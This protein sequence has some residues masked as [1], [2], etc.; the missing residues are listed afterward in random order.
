MSSGCSL[1]SRLSCTLRKARVSSYSRESD[2]SVVSGGGENGRRRSLASWVP[3]G[4]M[5]R[6]LCLIRPGA[7]SAAPL[8]ISCVMDTE[9][10]FV[11]CCSGQLGVTLPEE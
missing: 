2:A 9:G 8:L 5:E 6:M 7:L 1:G 10:G 3:S 11:C 4:G